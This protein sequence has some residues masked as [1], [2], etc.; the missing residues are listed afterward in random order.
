MKEAMGCRETDDVMY[1]NDF[2]T[3][4]FKLRIWT[5]FIIDTNN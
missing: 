2:E 3:F 4:A 1:V 5:L